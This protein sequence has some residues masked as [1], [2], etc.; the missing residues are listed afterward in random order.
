MLV[1]VLL[2]VL[3]LV[4]VILLLLSHQP[5][6]TRIA[7]ME[8]R[9]PRAGGGV[10]VG[11]SRATP[12][13]RFATALRHS[14]SPFVIRHLASLFRQSPPAFRLRGAAVRFREA[15]VRFLEAAFRFRGA[16]IC[17]R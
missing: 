6:I 5:R 1:L 14:T 16:A 9:V 2:L 10:D 15:A 3:V 7:R 12:D 8:K 4:L 17:S 13:A 11:R